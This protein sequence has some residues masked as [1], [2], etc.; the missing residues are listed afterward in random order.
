MFFLASDYAS[1]NF[2]QFLMGIN[3]LITASLVIDN[4]KLFIDHSEY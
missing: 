2:N 1:P 3:F 4:R